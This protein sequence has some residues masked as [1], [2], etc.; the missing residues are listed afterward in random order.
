MQ[1]SI[2]FSTKHFFNNYGVIQISNKN[3]EKGREPEG[4]EFSA[5]LHIQ[6]LKIETEPVKHSFPITDPQK[7]QD[8]SI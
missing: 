8:E 4:N 5:S 7:K 3:E 1:C 2:P 6:S